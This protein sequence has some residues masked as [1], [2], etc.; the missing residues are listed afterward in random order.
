M[1]RKK[2]QIEV[3]P[4][5]EYT[6]FSERGKLNGVVVTG[7]AAV[8][9]SLATYAFTRTPKV[10]PPQIVEGVP[11][12]IPTLEPVNVWSMPPTIPVSAPTP[13]VIQTGF[14]AD[15]SLDVLTTI[16]DPLIQIMVAISFPIASVIMIGACFFFMFGNSEKGWS[17]IMNAGL[18]YVLINLSPLFLQILKQV[19]SSV[20]TN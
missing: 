18:G 19:G 12:I 20:A 3:V 1:F 15:T 5:S 16:L 13:D 10:I 14:V 4:E 9:A 6:D 2:K 7:A 8:T 17:T 11:E